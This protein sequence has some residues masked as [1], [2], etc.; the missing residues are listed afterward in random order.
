MTRS[1]VGKGH[2]EYYQDMAEQLTAETPGAIYI[3]QFANPANPLAHETR[4][5][6]GDLASR[7]S[8]EIDAVV[9]GVGSG[10][11]AHRHR[12]LH[13][14]RVAGDARWCWPIPAARC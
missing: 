13:A 2:P 9:C 1:D 7:W 6:A 14:K 8:T 3:N 5:G 12:A 11:H 10:R 4:H